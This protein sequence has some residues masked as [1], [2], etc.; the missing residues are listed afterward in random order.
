MLIILNKPMVIFW[1]TDQQGRFGIK[2]KV[3]DFLKQKKKNGIK[4]ELD[5]KLGTS[6]EIKPKTVGVLF[7]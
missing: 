5:L 6:H 7:P 3:D 2:V 4:L 1:M